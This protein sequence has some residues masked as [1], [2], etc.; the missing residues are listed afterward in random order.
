MRRKEDELP[1]KKCPVCGYPLQLRYKQHYGLRL[2][3]CSNEPEICD[4]MTNN[5]RGG[6]LSILKCN[7]CQDGYLIV[8]EGRKDGDAP[9]LGCTNYRKDRTGCNCTMTSQYYHSHIVGGF[10]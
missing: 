1:V 7:K 2:W 6:D 3:L 8:K 10:R 9:F 5:L 4:F